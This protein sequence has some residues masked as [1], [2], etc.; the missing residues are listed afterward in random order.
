MGSV[1]P[2]RLHSQ[3]AVAMH[4]ITT[5]NYYLFVYFEN[6]PPREGIATHNA[7]DV[8]TFPVY[9]TQVFF[10]FFPLAVRKNSMVFTRKCTHAHVVTAHSHRF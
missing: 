6:S 7:I 3:L 10:L 4:H 8:C 2:N 5:R 9:T 1:L